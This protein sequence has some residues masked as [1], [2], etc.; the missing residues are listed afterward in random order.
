MCVC[1][2]YKAIGYSKS[3]LQQL[4]IAMVALELAAGG[5][6]SLNRNSIQSLNRGV[7]IEAE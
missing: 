5:R 3:V 4:S 7:T 1:L 6:R 2:L